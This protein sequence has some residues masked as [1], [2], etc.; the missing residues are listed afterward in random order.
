LVVYLEQNYQYLENY[1]RVELPRI[2]VMKPEGTYLTWL[3]FRDYGMK[4]TELSKFIVEKAGVGLNNGKRFG[5]GGDGWMRINIGCP[6]SIL[7][8]GLGRIKQAFDSI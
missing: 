4:D 1:F 5:T 8:E 3:D 2:K 6:R 7:E